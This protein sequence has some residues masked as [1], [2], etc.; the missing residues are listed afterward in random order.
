M[1]PQ[2]ND[3]VIGPGRF[4]IKPN[5]QN[6]VIPEQKVL[7]ML[8]GSASVDRLLACFRILERDSHSCSCNSEQLLLVC[9]LV[10]AE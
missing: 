5:I 6:A 8:V 1:Q 10:T 2:D 4:V 9:F 3:I 7:G